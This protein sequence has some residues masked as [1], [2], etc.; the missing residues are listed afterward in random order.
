MA[1]STTNYNLT[2]YE[3]DDVPTW[4]VGWNNTMTTLDSTIKSVDDKACKG[5]T[6]IATLETQMQTAQQAIEQHGTDIDTN[7][8]DIAGLKAADTA[9]G[10]RIDQQ[11]VKI[12]TLSGEVNAS[13]DMIGKAYRGVLSTGE[14]TLS[15]IVGEIT[16]NTLVDVY[17][18]KEIVP[19]SVEVRSQEPGNNNLVVMTFEQQEEDVTVAVVCR[20]PTFPV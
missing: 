18:S 13:V 17:I 6:D 3:P 11:D 12:E 20:N 5:A 4:L 7:K 8:T 16:D 1:Q 10:T 15:I 2:L 14:T 9:M 19:N